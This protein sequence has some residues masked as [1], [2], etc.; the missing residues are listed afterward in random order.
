MNLI[1]KFV[2]NNTRL[3][4]MLTVLAALLIGAG[5]TEL[6]RLNDENTRIAL[7][8]TKAERS[9]YEMRLQTLNGSLMG[10]IGLVCL[11][12]D[13]VKQEGLGALA[14][15]GPDVSRLMESLARAHDADGAFVVGQDGV[16]KSSWGEGKP[17]T[18]V[19]VNFRPY[20]R[21]ALQGRENVYAAIG[22]TTGRRTLYFA[23]PVHA[24]STSDTPVIGAVAARAGAA[25]LD[26]LLVGKADI[27]LLLSPQGGV[28]ASNRDDWIGRLAGQVTPERIKSMREVK[29]FG[30]L[31]DNKDPE[32]LP[33]AIDSDTTVLEGRLHAVARA[34]VQW[35]DPNGD[36]TLVL[37]ED[38]NRSAPLIHHVGVGLASGLSVLILGWMLLLLIR[39]HYRQTIAREQLTA[40]GQAQQASAERK[41]QLAAAA[42]Q[43][44]QAKSIAELARTFLGETHRMLGAL[45]GVVYLFGPG[46]VS[47]RLAG[48]YACADDLPDTL[49]PG[50]GLLGQCVVDRQVQVIDTE[51]SGFGSIHSG[52]GETRPAALLLAPLLL[53]EDVLGAVEIALLTHPD[54]PALEQFKAMTGLLAMNHEIIGRSV[55]T[56]EALT[57][58]VAAQR[59]SAEQLAFQQAL[60]DTIPYPVFYKGPDNR[61]LGF[62]RAYE[63]AF[64]VRR[65]ALIGKQVL[66][67]DYLPEADRLSYQAEDEATIAAA[68]SVKREVKLPYSD[69]KLHDTLYFVS[70]FRRQDGSPGGLVGTFIDISQIK[71]AEAELARLADIERFNRL[72][73]GRE[74]RILELKQEINDLAQAA[75]R[76]APYATTIVE[77]VGD[78]EVQSHPD[79]RTNLEDDG[80]PTQL[81]D[82]VDLAELQGLFASYCESVG[83]AAAIIDMEGKVLASARWQRA[84]TDFHRVNPDSCAR[85]VESDTELALRLQDGQDYTMYT[86]KNG[87]TDCASPIIVEGQHLANVFIGQFHL[88]PPDLEFFRC[89]A[90]QF[91][92]PEADY[93][94][95]VAEAPVADETRLPVILGFLSGFARLVSTMSL[96]RRRA[97]AAQQRL[98]EQ[99]ELLRRERLAAMSLAEDNLRARQA[100]VH[101]MEQQ[102]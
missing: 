100:P 77:T 23:A 69:G 18:G 89:Q 83:I 30:T 13:H 58:T 29:Q 65:D 81:A 12:N 70:G 17:L 31:F 102:P 2:A 82:L 44:Q 48:S 95:A 76:P 71:N 9:G 27:A 57:V 62:N 47:M 39:G 53:N 72:A 98:Q 35:N 74:R 99:A 93:L 79:Y 10:A 28:F 68:G 26:K 40:Y 38:L 15:N 97:D 67:L 14:P 94:R 86:C 19:D 37:M 78:H 73:H 7:L 21:T 49:A 45:Q 3:A 50:E 20:A 52:L 34:T 16:I 36:W 55:H 33:F 90:Q 5:A 87:M 60:V 61:F 75:G 43:L 11:I 80:A 88:G 91:G 24:G 41:A 32:P 6:A 66:D 64:D 51:T 59:A 1:M 92:Y 85:C 56:E 54:E 101:E 8:Q 22:T 96:A 63:E 42:L 46:S 25:R 84:C 4:W